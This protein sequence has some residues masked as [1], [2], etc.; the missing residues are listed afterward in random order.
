MLLAALLAVR[1]KE[2]AFT[3]PLALALAEFLLFPPGGRRRWLPIV[4]VGLLALLIPA[5]WMDISGPVTSVLESA[6]R[7]SR[8]QT[9]IPRLDYLRTQSA[10][11]CEY[12]RL[13]A[14]PAGQNLD[15]D[16]PVYTSWLEP[17]VLGSVAFLALLAAF[18]VWSARRSAPRPGGPLL[19]PS[20]RLVAFGIGWFFLTLVVESSVI[21]IVD[22]IY[23]HRAYLPG[24]GIFV[25]VA[26]LLGLL[27]Q[28]IAP[29]ASTRATGLVGIALALVLGSLTMQRNAVWADPVSLWSDVVEKSPN[30]F[31]PHQNLGESLD[32]AGRLGAAEREFRRAVEIEPGSIV[33][34][35]SLATILQKSGRP[36]EAE[37]EYREALRVES[38]HLPALFNL[39]ELLWSSGRRHEAAS[40]YRRFLELGPRSG[41]ARSTAEAR[42]GFGENPPDRGP[43]PSP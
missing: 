26:T 17:R 20:F 24:V 27:L 39:A 23:E 30:K 35:T 38:E 16:F 25:A 32:A 29:G 6:D 3:L 10:V 12:L 22:V 34:R 8:L 28:R 31:R 41:S 18:A 33:A 36:G 5:T 42:A 19:D 14:W 15:H 4:P 7:V 43:V 1:T 11:I 13:L 40:L 9:T 37:A 21:P 2:I